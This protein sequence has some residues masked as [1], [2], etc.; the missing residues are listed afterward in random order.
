M[1]TTGKALLEHWG[2]A[3]K[4]GLMNRNTGNALRSACAKVLPV[5]ED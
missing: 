5:M 2:W 4:K 1:D 3:I